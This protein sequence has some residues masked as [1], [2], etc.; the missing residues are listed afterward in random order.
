MKCSLATVAFTVS[1]VCGMALH[2]TPARAGNIDDTVFLVGGGRD[3]GL[4]A[5]ESPVNGVRIKLPD[6][7]IRTITPKDV[8][9]VNYGGTLRA[10]TPVQAT[11]PAVFVGMARLRLRA[12]CGPRPKVLG[13]KD[14]LL[15]EE[16]SN[17]A[18]RELHP[19]GAESDFVDYE[20]PAGPHRISIRAKRC[21]AHDEDVVLPSGVTTE[22]APKLQD[23]PIALVPVSFPRPEFVEPGETVAVL[24]KDGK[25]V[26]ANLPCKTAVPVIDHHYYMTWTKD[27]GKAVTAY[28]PEPG[29]DAAKK[30]FDGRIYRTTSMGYA[31]PITMGIGGILVAI[32][33]YALVVTKVAVATGNGGNQQDDSGAVNGAVGVMVAGGVVALTGVVFW[34]TG[35]GST[36]HLAISLENR[37]PKTAKSPVRL[38]P[39]GAGISF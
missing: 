7:S 31:A 4:V 30:S 34:L 39:G 11:N 35:V 37:D 3:R 28:L 18:A 21:D 5:E 22:L 25:P 27:S 23:T 16:T 26:C 10:A 20:L 29:E 19:A 9:H 14:E 36:E 33:A 32:G 12:T 17:G 6:G 8:D 15:V 38:L 13:K 1:M 2:A 24:D